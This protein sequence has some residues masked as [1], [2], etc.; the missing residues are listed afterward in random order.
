MWSS[1]LLIKLREKQDQARGVPWSPGKCK[2]AIMNGLAEIN[3]LQARHWTTQ[4]TLQ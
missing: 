1:V 3:R 2:S 4:Y